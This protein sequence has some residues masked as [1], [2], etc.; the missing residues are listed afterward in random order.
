MGKKKNTKISSPTVSIL[1]PTRIKRLPYLKLLAKTIQNQDYKNIQEWVV[2]SGDNQ[3]K[4]QELLANE[5][6]KLYKEYS[7]PKLVLVDS[8]NEDK[9]IGNLRYLTNENSTGEILVCMD[10]DDIYPINRVSHAVNKL[11]KSKRLAAG[12]SN[13]VMHD[14]DLGET[15]QY[16]LKKNFIGNGT[17][18]Y[19]RE[20]LQITNYDRTCKAN[21]EKEFLKNYTIEYINL[22]PKKV[23]ILNSHLDNFFSKRKHIFTCI[24]KNQGSVMRLNNYKLSS[25]IVNDY[26]AVNNSVLPKIDI[27]FFLGLKTPKW[28]PTEKSKFRI[29]NRFLDIINNVN[30]SKKI[31]IYGDFTFTGVEDID[32]I[33]KE[34]SYVIYNEI[35]FINAYK[36]VFTNTY[37]TIIFESIDG[38]KEITPFLKTNYKS[39]LHIDNLFTYEKE[40]IQFVV[41][42]I[43]KIDKIILTNEYDKKLLIKENINT[44][45]LDDKISVIYNRLEEIDYEKPDGIKFCVEVKDSRLMLE[46]MI[47]IVYPIL[48]KNLKNIN[49]QVFTTH[50]YNGKNRDSGISINYYYDEPQFVN[51]IVNSHF[52]L[53]YNQ[54]SLTLNLPTCL[55]S[56]CMPILVDY[57]INREIQNSQEFNKKIADLSKDTEIKNTLGDLANILKDQCSKENGNDND[58]YGN[59]L[60][61]TGELI[62]E[63]MGENGEGLGQIAQLFGGGGENKGGSNPLGGIMSGLLGG[64]GPNT[65]ID[66]KIAL[67]N[68][69]IV[70][71]EGNGLNNKKDFRDLAKKL[72]QEIKNFDDKENSK[73]IQKCDYNRSL[74]NI[75]NDWETQLEL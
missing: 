74:E 6:A 60:N 70:H 46:Y 65:E 10:D 8:E 9:N 44:S 16:K 17:L 37:E 59:K 18:A 68:A 50:I 15:V 34:N 13:I 69:P 36:F 2:V 48:K 49:F 56:N 73:K 30:K 11:V 63:L 57:K 53:F 47:D 62:S 42:N 71:I 35:L 1:T 41:Q 61:L 54:N 40:D 31:A 3:I 28:N 21:E 19:K 29:I 51:A 24:H 33:Y 52:V 45:N 55:A 27:A 22:E 14:L 7:L 12:L 58:E 26:I 43:D 39:I 20:I 5:L 4:D 64:N 67:G 66:S 38:Y 72:A 25:E 75:I 23:M 32:K